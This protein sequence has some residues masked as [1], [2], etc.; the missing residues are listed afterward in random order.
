MQLSGLGGGQTVVK[1]HRGSSTEEAPGQL[2]L[3]HCRFEM[4][5]RAPRSSLVTSV[6]VCPTSLSVMVFLPESHMSTAAHLQTWRPSSNLTPPSAATRNLCSAETWAT[7]QP[8]PL[9]GSGSH[10]SH[11]YAVVTMYFSD[12]KQGVFLMESPTSG[13]LG[14]E[15]R[16]PV[17]G[18]CSFCPLLY[19]FVLEE[20]R[21]SRTY[22]PV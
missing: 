13:T 15:D 5:W 6:L 8:S 10:P 9:P 12:S 22:P 17:V 7:D 16:I 14:P 2:S 21:Q 4:L 11:N 1:A 3:G 18:A 19:I 20:V